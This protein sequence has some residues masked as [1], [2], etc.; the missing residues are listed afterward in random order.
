MPGTTRRRERGSVTAETAVALPALVLVLT[1]SLWAVAATDAQLRCVDAAR[2]G[3]RAAARGEAPEQVRAVV[4]RLA[5]ADTTV[6]VAAGAGT[7]RVEVTATVRPLWRSFLPPV[8]LR[9][10]AVSDTEPGV[11]PPPPG[12]LGSANRTPAQFTTP[13]GSLSSTNRTPARSMPST[14]RGAPGP[15]TP[16]LPPLS[17]SSGAPRTSGALTRRERDAGPGEAHGGGRSSPLL[18]DVGTQ[19]RR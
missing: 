5:P 3:A 12:S 1:A 4:L 17:M 16:A 14:P 18:D 8:R 6:S 10:S 13:P 15:A 19:E 7:V 11:L 2:A 9:A